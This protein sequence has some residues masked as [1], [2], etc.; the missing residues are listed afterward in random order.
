M[1]INN[2]SLSKVV[3]PIL[4]TV[5]IASY[6]DPVF[7]E[8]I[9]YAPEKDSA[10]S[11][12][13]DMGKSPFVDLD[14]DGT[15]QR[16]MLALQRGLWSRACSVATDALAKK[17]SNLDALGIFAVCQALVANKEGTER[18]EFRLREVEPSPG[19]YTML[20][21]GVANL[22]NGSNELAENAFKRLLEIRPGDPVGEYFLGES[23]HARQKDTE[24]IAIF[25]KVLKSWPDYAP[26][27]SATA[28]LMAAKSGSKQNLN[29]AISMSERAAR[30][31]PMNLKYWEQTATLC[32]QAGQRDRAH[33]IRLQWLYRPSLPVK[34]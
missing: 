32:D 22:R 9:P 1:F 19:Y 11:I 6:A 14:A 5:L 24:A 34:K 33:A 16:I 21:N 30:I 3:L 25:Q 18:A 10:L 17:E 2:H 20:T 26:A 7:C 4:C 13:P 8:I 15:T 29:V 27:L 31:D 23:L 12:G 28:R